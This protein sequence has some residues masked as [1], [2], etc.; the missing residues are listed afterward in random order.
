M[1]TPILAAAMVVCARYLGHAIGHAVSFLLFRRA[2][3]N[4]AI[5]V[6]VTGCGSEDKGNQAPEPDKNA[7]ERLSTAEVNNKKEAAEQDPTATKRINHMDV[8]LSVTQAM[9]VDTRADIPACGEA[10]K[11]QLIYVTE[12]PHPTPYVRCRPVSDGYRTV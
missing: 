5:A 4:V 9:L 3:L 11:R 2:V 12:Q 1:L 8:P 7:P 6:W 10:N